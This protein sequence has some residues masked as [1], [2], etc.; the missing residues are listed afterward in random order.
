MARLST[1]IYMSLMSKLISI[2]QFPNNFVYILDLRTWMDGLSHSAVNSSFHNYDLL[3]VTQSTFQNLHTLHLSHIS[4][5]TFPGYTQSVLNTIFWVTF[6]LALVTVHFTNSYLH[7]QDPAQMPV[8]QLCLLYFCQTQ[9]FQ[10][11][12]SQ[13]TLLLLVTTMYFNLSD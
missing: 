3:F 9:L 2:L 7:I 4:L 12:Y 6:L 8:I 5:S 10:S 11:P 1:I 13:S